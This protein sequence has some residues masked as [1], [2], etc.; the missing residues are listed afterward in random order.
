MN[1]ASFQINS[2]LITAEINIQNRA[3]VCKSNDAFNRRKNEHRPLVSANE[4]WINRI[5][6]MNDR[7]DLI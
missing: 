2:Y 5:Y 7:D 4:F 6:T 1:G 3:A